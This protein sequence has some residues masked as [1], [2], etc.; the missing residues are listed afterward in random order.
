M[1]AVVSTV[2][3]QGKPFLIGT[4]YRADGT[5]VRGAATSLEGDRRALLR[6]LAK[7]LADGTAGPTLNI[8]GSGQNDAP[9]VQALRDSVRQPKKW[10]SKLVLA[11]GGLAVAA[12]SVAFMATEADDF[13]PPTSDDPRAPAVG[14]MLGGSAV[15]GTGVYLWLRESRTTSALAAAL[16][17]SGAASIVAGGAL[18]LTDEDQAPYPPPNQWQRETYRDSATLGVVVGAAGVALMGAGIWLRHREHHRGPSPTASGT[19]VSVAPERSLVMWT[20]RF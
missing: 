13:A 6:S 18:F 8:I 19:T 17:G 3:L 16:V 11:A 12:G 9:P 5:I 4:L 10:A 20:G 2:Q 15:I 1:M 7:Y 14:V